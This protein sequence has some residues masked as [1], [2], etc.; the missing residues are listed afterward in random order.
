MKKSLEVMTF[1][2]SILESFSSKKD[3]SLKH[4]ARLIYFAQ[5]TKDDHFV[6]WR[7]SSNDISKHI[8]PEKVCLILSEISSKNLNV[9]IVSFS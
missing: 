2:N 4:F 7:R 6:I 1:A 5:R 9:Y 8:Y 3:R